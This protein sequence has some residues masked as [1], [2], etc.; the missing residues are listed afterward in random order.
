MEDRE[1]ANLVRRL[2]VEAC[3]R[4]G[5][6]RLKLMLITLGGYTALL[7]FFVALVGLLFWAAMA[8]N[9]LYHRLRFGLALVVA[10]PL[11]YVV[12]RTFFMR[13]P[14]P[15]GREL[16]R[17]DAPRLFELLDKMQRRVA[18]PPV[19]QVLLDERFNAAI[20]QVP[21]FG[22]FGGHRN[23]LIL[24][25]PMLLGCRPSEFAATLAHEY[26]HIAGSHGK[27][28]AWIYRQRGTFAAFQQKIDADAQE[29]NL[30]GL[31][32]RL[33]AYYAPWFNAYTF[34]AARQQEFDA[35]NAA[36]VWV[37]VEANA[38]G[39]IRGNLLSPWIQS[40]FWPR[41]YQQVGEAEHPRYLPYS[42]MRTA[43]PACEK[44]WATPERLAQV[45]Q[46]KTELDD[47]HPSLSERLNAIGAP[48]TLPRPLDK[49]ALDSFFAPQFAHQIIKEFDDGWWEEQKEQ[50]EREYQR[51]KEGR[52]RLALLKGRV[53]KHLNVYEMH[54]L[55]QLMAEFENRDD[56]IAILREMLRRPDGPFARSEALLGQLL[57]EADRAEGLAHC[58]RAAHL[59]HK[60]R[61]DCAQRGYDFLYRTQGEAEASQWA[62]GLFEEDQATL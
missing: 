44:D 22:L 36:S 29:S 39:L 47:T 17:E 20:Q 40:D 12:L 24:G 49:N 35:D 7:L 8:G 5:L 6:F 37:G 43:F 27:F 10:V 57:L 58:A 25:L 21:R 62:R 61:E 51:L 2:E 32:Q 53:G 14:A 13:L 30:Y 18:G 48:L 16:K 50:W 45:G 55:A 42:A 33:L 38:G 4:P 1:F 11:L 15:A 28:G 31:I 23:Y 26:G 46:Q 19:D 59:D 9:M 3:A 56:A 52:Q 41:L 34:V 60:L 54:E